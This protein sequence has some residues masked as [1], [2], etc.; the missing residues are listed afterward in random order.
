MIPLFKVFL[1]KSIKKP[2]LDTL[3]S[4]YIGQGPKVDEFEEKLS[5]FIGNPYVL[6]VNS[7]TSALHLSLSLLNVKKGDEVITTPLTCTATNWPVLAHQAKIVWA[8]TDSKTANIDPESI[9]EKITKNTKAIIVVDWGGQ[10]VDI[11]KI[12]KIAFKKVNGKKI[13]ISIIE[14]AAHAFGAEYKNR[15]V[16]NFADFTCFSF[17]AI[18]HMTTIDGGALF[19]LNK[20]HY[21]RGKLLRWYGIDRSKKGRDSR[22]EENIYEWGYKFHMNDIN[23]AIGIEQLKYIKDTLKKH[24]TNAQY[25]NK[26]LNDISELT[27]LESDP[28][29]LSSYWI[30]TM[31]VKRRDAFEDM[32]KK[33]GVMTSLVHRRNDTHPVVK[34]FKT[35]L[36]NL[37]R[38]DKERICIPVGWWLT[39]EDLKYIVKTIKSGW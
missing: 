34:Q 19:V 8:D 38:I 16:G 11:N 29:S 37:D 28:N 13:K 12:K 5:S 1:P 4:G 3:F 36:P 32:M 15:K 6:T 17:Q 33:A 25:Y 35:K 18:K 20:K 24:R 31:L 26:N 7:A 30:F 10:P 2:L 39:K 23:A 22:I 9:K 21:E 27:L 14:D